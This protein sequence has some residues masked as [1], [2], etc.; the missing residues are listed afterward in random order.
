M[1]ENVN[2]ILVSMPYTGIVRPSVA[3]GLLV[4]I[5]ERDGL[6]AECLYADI[7]FAEEI[8]LHSYRVVTHSRAADALADWTFS[9]IAFP[10]FK[11]NDD[12]FLERFIQRN[13]P[14]LRCEPKQLR[15]IVYPI[16]DAAEGFINQLAKHILD[17]GLRMIGCSS[18][19]TQHVSSLALLRR[20]HEL[21]PEVIT[22]MGGANCETIMG[23]TTH[24]S[25]PWVDYVVSGEADRLI[26]PLVRAIL[27]HGREIDP[28]NLPEGLFAPVHRRK[29]YPRVSTDEIDN[30]PRATLSSLYDLPVPNYDDYFRALEVTH[31]LRGIILPA[32]TVETSRGCWWG[33]KR[34]CTF[35]GRSRRG[36]Q[37]R[38]K[39][40]KQVIREL[41]T[42]YRRYGIRRFRM[43]DDIMDM[44]YFET[45]LP[46][47]SRAGRPYQLFY[48]MKA[49][50]KKEQVKALLEAG[51]AFIQPGIESLHDRILALLNK[52]CKAW[53]N[54]LLLKWCRQ[55]GIFCRFN[56]LCDVPGEE[57]AWYLQ[58]AELFPLLVHLQPP[59][60]LVRLR[61]DRY[62]HYHN[63]A[64][65]YCLRMRPA[66]LYPYIYPLSDD[67]LINLVYY[68]EDEE[69]LRD[70]LLSPLL[71]RPGIMAVCR[72]IA[73]WKIGFWSKRRPLLTMSV[74]ASA[75]EIRDTRPVAAV[76]FFTLEGLEREI[77]LACDM[78]NRT[79]QLIETFA[80][81][82]RTRSDVQVAIQNLLDRK[83]MVSLDDR[84]LALA[85]QEPFFELPE[86][87]LYP[88]GGFVSESKSDTAPKGAGNRTVSFP[89]L[90]EAGHTRQSS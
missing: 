39:S 60:S 43:V 24:K 23:L 31:S 84:L 54:I 34:M 88:E 85:V 57:D 40:A 37:F 27:E 77:Y 71:T 72:G 36:K 2:I 90:K 13:R 68:F 3:L 50:L 83:L 69:R 21:A 4:A 74:S 48:E 81:G 46:L 82:N 18:T 26:V 19:F 17:R 65:D 76:P 56:I 63:H 61:F 86:E 55:Y 49:N 42:L 87:N 53:Q 32:L 66:E 6:A 58:M 51:I 10:N 78:G 12:A 44:N 79:D 1:K 29:G 47:L 67:D 14:Y 38:S 20:I 64:E 35:C 73:R 7:L 75:V 16:R 45:F 30:V 5:L 62:S 11:P 15:D 22:L 28:S 25:F 89:L 33:E 59:Y 52:G 9:H 8:G 80:K 70:P 41:D